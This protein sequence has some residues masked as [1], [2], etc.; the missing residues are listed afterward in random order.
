MTYLFRSLLFL[1]GLVM[2]SSCS[3]KSESTDESSTPQDTTRYEAGVV[4]QEKVDVEGDFNGDGKTETAVLR[5]IKE[6]ELQSTPWIYTLVFSDPAIQSLTFDAPLESPIVMNES[7]INNIPGDELT[8]ITQA[9]MMGVTGVN[10]Y[11]LSDGMWGPVMEGFGSK[12]MLPDSLSF[13]DLVFTENGKA[14]YF[15]FVDNDPTGLFEPEPGEDNREAGYYKTEARLFT[16]IEPMSNR[17]LEDEVLGSIDVDG[18]GEEEMM[19]MVLVQE[20]E[21]FATY[22]LEFSNPKI[23]PLAIGGGRCGGVAINEGDLDGMPGSELSLWE[24]GIMR[25]YNSISTFSYINS[26]WKKRLD[27]LNTRDIMPE[28]F[29]LEDIIFK[30][31]GEVYYYEDEE[32]DVFAR[33]GNKAE[34]KRVKAELK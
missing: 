15:D 26:R 2:V 7:K 31:N 12:I 1:T 14:F 9:P 19:R 29:A 3:N 32:L 28:G 4:T 25:N 20:A 16:T 27:G 17:F 18:D 6:G 8:I 30:E 34:M 23:K 24:C 10:V 21:E 22:R 11:G 13:N 33:T 5:M